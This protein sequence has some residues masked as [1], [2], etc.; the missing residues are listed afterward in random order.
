MTPVT[1]DPY[2]GKKELES[3]TPP[4]HSDEGIKTPNA[5]NRVGE[6]LPPAKEGRWGPE[7]GLPLRSRPALT[8]GAGSY[9]AG[10]S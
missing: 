5:R 4:K 2:A 8:T 10:R 3:L 7:P 1:R 9:P 6:E